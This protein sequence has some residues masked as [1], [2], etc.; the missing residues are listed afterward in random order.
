MPCYVLCSID[1]P[2]IWEPRFSA[3]CV[4]GRKGKFEDEMREEHSGQDIRISVPHVPSCSLPKVPKCTKLTTSKSLMFRFL[5]WLN[6][7]ICWDAQPP[8]KARMVCIWLLFE[9][10][11]GDVWCFEWFRQERIPKEGGQDLV[12]LNVLIYMCLPMFWNSAPLWVGAW[13]TPALGRCYGTMQKGT[14]ATRLY[15]PTDSL[16]SS[17]RDLRLPAWWCSL[18]KCVHMHGTWGAWE[19]R[20]GLGLPLQWNWEILI[21]IA[22]ECCSF[23]RFHCQT[24]AKQSASGWCPRSQVPR[25]VFISPPYMK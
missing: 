2:G 25:F 20:E 4:H 11:T 5:E 9:P 6:S 23:D 14:H 3:S 24:E 22:K 15:H 7:R 16:L 19:A 8:E 12:G 18:G 17:S 10:I 21:W 13:W 1:L